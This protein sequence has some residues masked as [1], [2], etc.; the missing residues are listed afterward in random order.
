M[1]VCY[2]LYQFAS[3]GE[4]NPRREV[5]QIIYLSL[6]QTLLRKIKTSV[7]IHIYTHIDQSRKN[8]YYSI[9]AW[10]QRKEKKVEWLYKLPSMKTLLFESFLSSNIGWKYYSVNKTQRTTLKHKWNGWTLS[11]LIHNVHQTFSPG[12]G[13]NA[14]ARVASLVYL[15]SSLLLRLRCLQK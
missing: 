5:T 14:K 9:K 7:I 4:K 2:H 8:S 10:K 12:A 11:V 13:N 6:K 3:E 1:F 15:F